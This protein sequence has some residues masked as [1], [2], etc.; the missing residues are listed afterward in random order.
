[1]MTETEED[2]TLWDALTQDEVTSLDE[3]TTNTVVDGD[4]LI[5]AHF[6]IR[7]A[8]FHTVFKNPFA[9]WSKS[10]QFFEQGSRVPIKERG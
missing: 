5:T 4:L 8:V 2:T 9:E 7:R 6:G 10:E 3:A 1:M